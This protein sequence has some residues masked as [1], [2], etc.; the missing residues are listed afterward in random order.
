MSEDIINRLRESTR[1]LAKISE[2]LT[3]WAKAFRDIADLLA[4]KGRPKRN[5]SLVGHEGEL[6]L[7]GV[8]NEVHFNYD[9]LPKS[10]RL[11]QLLDERDE[12]T[13]A[14]GGIEEMID[15]ASKG[16]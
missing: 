14:I 3:G 7:D 2:E 16:K 1:Q 11:I 13:R 12:L 8:H 9:T 5:K 15:A 6:L 10:K 4:G